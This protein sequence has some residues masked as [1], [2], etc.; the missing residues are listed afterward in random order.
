[1]KLGDLPRLLRTVRHLRGAQVWWRARYWLEHRRPPAAEPQPP[2]GVSERGGEF[3]RMPLFHRPGA[4]GEEAVAMVAA[5]DFA[6]LNRWQNLGRERPDWRLGAAAADRLWVTTLHHHYWV[7][8]L[9][10]AA[11]AADRTGEL[12]ASLLRHYLSDWIERCGLAAAGARELTWN[13]YA[14]ATRLSWWI[15]AW[16]LLGPERFGAS[17][18]FARKFLLS[19]WRQAAYLHRHLDGTCAATICCETRR[20]WPGPA[21]FSRARKRS[22]GCGPRPPWPRTRWTSRSW[23][24]G[25]SS[26]ARPCIICT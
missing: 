2:A 12:A 7:Y 15:R 11:A 22:S 14:V 20:A 25:D 9:A 23:R 6:H 4:T 18:E 13:A 26:S 17:P 5:G 19:A 16:R 10:E 24:T 3:P 21:D 1:M 8:D